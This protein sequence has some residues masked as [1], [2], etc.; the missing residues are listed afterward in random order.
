MERAL[1]ALWH[2]DLQTSARYHP[3]AIPFA[4]FILTLLL[5]ALWPERWER[6]RRLMDRVWEVLQSRVVMIPALIV[7][8]G[9]WVLRL[10]LWAMGD[11]TFM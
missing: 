2:G 1:E 10:V 3:L 7:F 6:S 5:S 4:L 9:T 11:D 8:L